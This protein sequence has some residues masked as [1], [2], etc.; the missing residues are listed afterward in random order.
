M[1]SELHDIRAIVTRLNG[2]ERP[3]EYSEKRISDLCDQVR[4]IRHQLYPDIW[5]D[6]TFPVDSVL[7]TSILETYIESFSKVRPKKITAEKE[8][9]EEMM[10]NAPEGF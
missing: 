9:F 5:T 4:T 2:T 1:V 10:K 3:S 7:I 8:Q 6:I